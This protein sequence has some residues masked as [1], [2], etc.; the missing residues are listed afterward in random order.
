MSNKNCEI[1]YMESYSA[2]QL[3]QCVF[4]S[5]QAQL[6][7]RDVMFKFYEEQ[8]FFTNHKRSPIGFLS[9][10]A[11]QLTQHLQHG[12]VRKSAILMA[13]EVDRPSLGIL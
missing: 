5:C 3:A 7:L 1:D 6:N 2:A 13:T 10:N 11:M 9:E 4:K 12:R 8:C